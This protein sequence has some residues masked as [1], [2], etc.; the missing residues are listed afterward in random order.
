MKLRINEIYLPLEFSEA[1]IINTIKR[2]LGVKPEAILSWEIYK[3]SI[4][5]RKKND[6]R[7]VLSVDV[8]TKYAIQIKDNKISPIKDFVFNI[9]NFEKKIP[10]PV[11]IGFGPAG[12]FSAL[13]LA[14]S[15]VR[16]IVIER[17]G[18]VED[19]EKSVNNFF[20]N[21]VLNL[22]SNVQFGEGGA[23]TFSDGKLN[24]G[25]K[26]PK[27][28]WILEEFV[29]AGAPPEILYE[30]KPHIGTDKL[31]TVVKNIREK[32]K[33]LGGEVFFDTK[34]TELVVEN[35]Q[36]KAVKAVSSGKELLFETSTAILAIGHSARDSFEMLYDMGVVIE[37]KSFSLGVRIEHKAE[38]INRS[39]YGNKFYDKLPTADY[40]LSAHLINGR[41]VYSFC[42]CPGGHVV[43]A[44][45]EENCVVTNGMSRYLRDAQNSNSAILVSVTQDDFKTEHPLGGMYMQREIEQKAFV[46]AGS[47]YNAPCQKFGDFIKGKVSKSWGEVTPSYQP[48]VSECDLNELFTPEVSQSICMGINQF[49]SRISGF[50]ND[51]AILTAPETRSS[52]PIRILRND[53]LQSV[54]V[55]GLYPCSEGAGYAG[56]ITSAALDGIR[57][58]LAIIED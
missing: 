24:T 22:D 37:Q 54:S 23:G 12:M 5:A 40:K 10:R 32:I 15:G 30:A 53:K 1:N 4:D 28:R 51:D 49:S 7:Y 38:L 43:G 33:S 44:T 36:L 29:L 18:C 20:T 9:K 14:K 35:S 47:N 39:Q 45:S 46:L 56:G 3:K 50:N 41:G 55:K 11:I 34:M 57:C 8:T 19:R 16:P 25:V 2:R 48:S 26:D 21:R 13:C 31:P 52:S 42:M 27:I 58:A 6:I 17:G